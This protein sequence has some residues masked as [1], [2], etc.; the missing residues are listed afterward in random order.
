[1]STAAPNLARPTI[2][3]MVA[4]YVVATALAFR[5]RTHYNVV[6]PN[7]DAGETVPP[8]PWDAVLAFTAGPIP[9]NMSRLIVELPNTSFD[10]PIM[11]TL[12]QQTSP[13]QV[14]RS[15]PIDDVVALL[16]HHLSP[17]V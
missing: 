11:V 13:V 14:T 8:R 4:P 17:P 9:R 10:D 12:N 5:L 15:H 1:M 2:L 16:Q 3:V 6:A 7:L